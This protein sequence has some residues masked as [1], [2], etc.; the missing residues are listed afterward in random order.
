MKAVFIALILAIISVSV[1]F[2][3]S[4]DKPVGAIVERADEKSRE[5]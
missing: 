5:L 4:Q 2:F 3:L 1:Y